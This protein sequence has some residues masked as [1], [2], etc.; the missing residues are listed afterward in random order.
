MTPPSPDR[1]VAGAVGRRGRRPRSRACGG[2]ATVASRAV[3]GRPDERR[4]RVGG[5]GRRRTRRRAERCSTGACARRP[6]DPVALFGRASIAYERGA[7]EQAIAGYAAVLAALQRPRPDDLGPLLAPV[8][9]GR[10]LTLYDEVGAATRQRIVGGLRPAE[11]ARAADLPWQARVEL[12]RLRPHAAREASDAD[13]AGAGRGAGRLR[14]TVFR[15]LGVV[16]PL[17]NIDLDAA[18]PSAWPPAVSAGGPVRASGCRL[19]SAATADGRAGRACCGSRSRRRRGGTTSCSTTRPRARLAID[20]GDAV[21]ARRG[22]ALR[23]A[24]LGDARRARGGPPRFGAPAR[25]PRRRRR[26]PCWV[27]GR[28]RLRP[29]PRPALESP[30][31]AAGAASSPATAGGRDGAAHARRIAA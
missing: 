11:L 23:T 31:D 22:D 20:G 2:C 13:R 25:D 29:L 4:W 28:R 16:G 7:P 9:A 26:A 6:A 21:G 8:A 10:L 5:A 27:R 1:P 14:A 30:S 18:P 12:A 24:P 17:P 3:A 15:F 19:E